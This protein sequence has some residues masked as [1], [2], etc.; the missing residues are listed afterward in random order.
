MTT[1]VQIRKSHRYLPQLRKIVAC[2]AAK[3]GMSW[4]DIADTEDAVSEICSISI[5]RANGKCE[6]NLFIKLV[7]YGTCMTVEVTDPSKAIDP[8]CSANGCQNEYR[9]VLEWDRLLELADNVE[10][11]RGDEGTTIR[12]IKYADRLRNTRLAE[13]SAHLSAASETANLHA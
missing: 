1:E 4:K 8:K 3:L 11:I 6:E 9:Q 13:E 5:D 10:L 7:V 2:L 12:I